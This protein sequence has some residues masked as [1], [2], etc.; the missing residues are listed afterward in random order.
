LKNWVLEDNA[1]FL[2]SGVTR[3]SYLFL[4]NSRE[5]DWQLFEFYLNIMLNA[6]EEQYG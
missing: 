4:S 2:K 6:K 5:G 1:E 3:S